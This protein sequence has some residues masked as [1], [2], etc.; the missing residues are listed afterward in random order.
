VLRKNF[1]SAEEVAGIVRDLSANPGLGPAEVA[2]MAYARKIIADASSVTEEDVAGLRAHGFSDAEVLDIAMVAAARSFFSKVLDA[3]GAEPDEEFR[4]M[5]PALRAALTV[6][7]Q[8][9]A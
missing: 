4:A 1:F 8:L 7:R 5:E 9:P 6:G 3:V 2:M